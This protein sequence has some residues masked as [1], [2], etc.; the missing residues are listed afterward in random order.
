MPGD[1]DGDGREDAAI[2]RNGAWWILRSFDSSVLNRDFGLS[3]DVP[4][5][6]DYDGDGKTDIAVFRASSGTWYAALSSKGFSTSYPD[7]LEKAW[8]ATSDIP[9][10]GD[11]D[12]DGRVDFAFFRPSNGTWN[13]LWSARLF[14][15]ASSL[16]QDYH[17]SDAF[18]HGAST[19]TPLHGDYDGDGKADL[20][21][22]TPSTGIWSI[23]LS[24]TGSLSQTQ[25]G[26]I[27][28]VPVPA[29]YTGDGK[30]DIGIYRSGVWW[31]LNS[32]G[33]AVAVAWGAAGDLPVRR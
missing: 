6:A 21:V 9:M 28:D 33:Q 7:Y 3:T 16:A 4:V 29:D 25:F 12:A 10:A 26:T 14:Q 30:T 22:F 32:S 11:Y 13:I 15:P 5:Q 18:A 1:Y 8:G 27:G 31:Y 2:L 17:Y 19:D 24:K 23:R 20:A